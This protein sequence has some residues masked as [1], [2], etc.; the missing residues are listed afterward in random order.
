MKTINDFLEINLIVSLNGAKIDEDD[1]VVPVSLSHNYELS[2]K[3]NQRAATADLLEE[4]AAAIRTGGIYGWLMQDA[5]NALV[6]ANDFRGETD[7]ERRIR[8]RSCLQAKDFD[9]LILL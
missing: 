8:Q 2:A 5:A 3:K 7:S 6:L 9:G 4:I 1:E